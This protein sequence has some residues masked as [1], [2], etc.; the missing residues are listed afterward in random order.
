MRR[1]A[2]V[3][4][5]LTDH[6][7]DASAP[8]TTT[9]PARRRQLPRVAWRQYLDDLS[10]V[11]SPRAKRSSLDVLKEAVPLSETASFPMW[12]MPVRTL[13]AMERLRPHEEVKSSLVQWNE[14]LP[15][16]VI[17]ISHTWLRFSHP[18]SEDGQKFKLLQH[19]LVRAIGGELE[20]NAFGLVEFF[21]DS[22]RIAAADLQADLS[23]GYV[24]LDFMSIPQAAAA[25]KEQGQAI[26]S[27]NSY[28]RS[29]SYFMCLAGPWRHENGSYRDVMA[30]SQRGWCRLEM[31]SNALSPN[32]KPIIVAQSPSDVLSWPPVGVQIGTSLLQCCVGKG[33]FTVSSDA[34]KLGP[35]I[36]S[37]I[38]ERKALALER[39]GDKELQFYRFLHACTDRML[40]GC[41]VSP[42]AAEEAE[43]YP[44]DGGALT[45]SSSEEP[46]SDEKLVSAWLAEMR[47][48]S[49]ADGDAS[50]HTWS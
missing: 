14:S 13:L 18:D 48:D 15:G 4:G 28:I 42:P 36:A 46:S 2:R 1:H 44:G 33:K 50:G 39:G 43:G 24:W 25:A 40:E 30:W 9:R 31:L 22:L 5:W 3:F 11:L 41:E 10:R 21:F 7:H 35:V 34:L 19:L 16:K 17:F 32:A 49:V 27:I 12:V 8:K 29:S 23:D 47:F 45:A 20:I 26:D 6:M 38:A 37:M